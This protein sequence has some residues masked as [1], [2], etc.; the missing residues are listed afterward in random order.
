MEKLVVTEKAT[1]KR[2]KLQNDIT[3]NKNRKNNIEH[4]SEIYK[5]ILKKKNQFDER[6]DDA[7]NSIYESISLYDG[8]AQKYTS[9]FDT[10]DGPT[11][12]VNEGEPTSKDE[13]S[14]PD[15]DENNP[16][17]NANPNPNPKSI[18]DREV[19]IQQQFNEV[20]RPTNATS[21]RPMNATSTNSDSGPT[22]ATPVH[23]FS[24]PQVPKGRTLSLKN[25]KRSRT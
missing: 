7:R 2:I 9:F 22:S 25:G 24:I 14:V 13:V 15:L 19:L 5:K 11:T 21:I 20:F 12:T 17:P 8:A 4:R 10:P 23:K 6:L 18:P 16:N 1:S 3:E